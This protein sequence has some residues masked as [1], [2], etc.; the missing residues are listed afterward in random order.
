MNLIPA[1]KEIFSR[2]SFG[3]TSR[4]SRQETATDCWN[5][6]AI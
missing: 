2:C 4:R 5:H 3:Y 1:T 6:Q